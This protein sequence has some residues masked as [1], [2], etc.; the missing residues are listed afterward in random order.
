MYP[1]LYH[2]SCPCDVAGNLP[3]NAQ[4][5]PQIYI[6]GVPKGVHGTLGGTGVG[7][8]GLERGW[9]GLG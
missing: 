2:R 7:A 8:G 1:Q 6:F 4:G 5:E 3:A 9:L